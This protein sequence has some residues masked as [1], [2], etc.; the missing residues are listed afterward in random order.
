MSQ[1]TRTCV[2]WIAA[3]AAV[4]V[5]GFD[6]P[7]AAQDSVR[8]VVKVDLSKLPHVLD[9]QVDQIVRQL[10]E[11]RDDI[12]DTLR[13]IAD[14]LND[15]GRDDWSRAAA[16]RAQQSGT[17]TQALPIDATGTLDIRTDNGSITVTAGSGAPS[18][19]VIKKARGR[20]DADARQAIDRVTVTVDGRNGRVR[21]E[22]NARGRSDVEVSFVVTAPAGIAVNARANNGT[23]TITGV[24][25]EVVARTMHG[26]ITLS[27]VPN[28]TE[29]HSYSGSITISDTQSE[30]SLSADSLSGSIEFH[31]VKARRIT[32]N[33]VTS[34][35]I[36]A[37]DVECGE[38]LLKSLNGSVTFRGPM[39]RN[40]H[41]EIHAF[42]GPVHFEPTGSTGFELDASSYSG[43]IRVN[44]PLRLQSSRTDRH[45]LTGTVGDGAATVTIETFSGSVSIG[46]S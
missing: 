5:L 43:T 24:R 38:A 39:A 40:G 45:S 41:Y 8:V 32:A 26:A 6:R 34:G 25:G 1:R 17:S 42:S 10:P 3:A 28:V 4:M 19:Q 14:S 30:R 44:P 7:L 13:D 22:P 11:I 12:S 16:G 31:R 23:V 33:T 37:D 9:E 18:L 20:S 46:K 2:A 36:L 29:A 21:V 15:I 35:P 27:N